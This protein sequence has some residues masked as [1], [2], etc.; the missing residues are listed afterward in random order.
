MMSLVTLPSPASAWRMPT[1]RRV[2]GAGGIVKNQ[3][4][5]V[6]EQR[7]ARCRGAAS[8]RPRLMPRPAPEWCPAIGHRDKNSSAR[9][10]R[11]HA[12]Q[13]RRPSRRDRPISGCRGSCRRTAGS[14][15]HDA[16]GVPQGVHVVVADVAP[17]TRTVPSVASYRRGMS[18]TQR[19]FGRARAADDAHRSPC[20]DMQG[21]V[22]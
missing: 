15:Q 17:P 13:G 12:A 18:W 9:A 22:G 19:R 21:D 5:R 14:L 4:L 8:A 3:H 2:H 11:R 7:R 20:R 10:A 6:L 16:D 1:R